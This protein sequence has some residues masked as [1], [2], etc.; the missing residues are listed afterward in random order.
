MKN[1]LKIGF[2]LV[3]ALFV[4][5]CK[6]EKI[7]VDKLTNFPPG[8]L[9]I[10]PADDSKVDNGDFDITV[11]FLSGSISTLA[12][13]T[14]TLKN[15]A[16]DVLTTATK[17]LSGTTD[18]IV[19]AGSEFDAANLPLGFYSIDVSVTDTEGKTQSVTTQFEI[20]NLPSVGII[21][22]ATPTGWDSDT[23]MEWVG[24]TSFELVITLTA[25]EVKFRAD[26]D[27]AVNWGAATFPTGTGTQ[28]G[29]N[30]PVTAGVWKVT[31]D[32]GTGAYSFTPAVVLESNATDLYLLGTFNN[33]QGSD[34][35]FNLV[36]N[37]TW[38]LDKILLAPG[39]LFKFSEGPNFMG[40]NW[41]D[42]NSDGKAELFGNNIAFNQPEGEA[43]YKVTFNDKTLNYSVEFVE[44]LATWS[45][46]GVIGSAAPNGWD[47]D[48]TMKDLGNG[49]YAIILGL[50]DGEIK[51]RADD[52]WALNWGGADFPA[53]T[54]TVNGPNIP[55]TKGLYR[56]D[57]NPSTGEYNITP[58]TIGIIGDATPT[59]WD[60]DTNMD[61]DANNPAIVTLSNFT[62]TTAGAKFRANDDWGF[63]WGNDTWPTGTG[64]P[65]GPN[66]PTQAGTYNISFN[67]NTGEYSFN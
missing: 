24:G 60:S 64:V 6:K 44:A 34:Y 22:S 18:S 19:I 7:D 67:V 45:T 20:F 31:F 35:K 8:I 39:D 29:P 17:S 47:S 53:G 63:N 37:N 26:N 15:D 42:S 43:Y 30:I 2:L 55:V 50:V 57:F 49:G 14:V 13:T 61:V 5:S 48:V 11:K 32:A 41:G 62:V 4:F 38:M 33:F 3:G 25:G 9:S 40:K 10:T 46:I 59:G 52:D 28:D 51:F 23:D 54:A 21:G 36:A 27:W 12:S 66:I 65:D 56:I 1:I 58:A 16:G